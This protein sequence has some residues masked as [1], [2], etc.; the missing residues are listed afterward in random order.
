MTAFWDIVPC[1][2]VEVDRRLE[3]LTASIITALMMEALRIFETSVIFDRPDYTVQYP[4][5]LSSSYSS[6]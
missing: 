5:R 4:T 6:S 1:R 3:V 2:P